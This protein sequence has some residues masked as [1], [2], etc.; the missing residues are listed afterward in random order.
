VESGEWRYGQAD[1]GG[2]WPSDAAAEEPTTEPAPNLWADDAPSWGNSSSFS[3]LPRQN[4][5]PPTPAPEPEPEPWRRPP[6]NLPPASWGQPAQQVTPPAP[7]L[8][9]LPA[10]YGAAPAYTP[11]TY[12]QPTSTTV[13]QVSPAGPT[14]RTG[15]DNWSRPDLTPR[16]SPPEED[17]VHPRRDVYGEEP[18]YGPLLGFT[19]GWYG[20]P[21]LFYLVWLITLDSDRQGLVWR[22]FVASLPW[23][24]AAVVLSLSV[25][26][27]LRWATVGWRTLTI[28]F[29]T[30]V[31]GAGVTTI[32]HSLAL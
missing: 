21:A 29:A 27:L 30:A 20:I 32:A 18:A 14:R 6:Q 7:A 28:S 8:P 4:D 23:L 9:Q 1:G 22:Q 3:W 2:P 19:A 12:T 10:T 11:P 31:I 25:A 24:V 26:G 15:F 17:E 13:S 16:V 5:G